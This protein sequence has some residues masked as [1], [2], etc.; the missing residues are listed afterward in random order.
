MVEV[1]ERELEMVYDQTI[2]MKS[3]PGGGEID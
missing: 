1:G 3:V 2:V